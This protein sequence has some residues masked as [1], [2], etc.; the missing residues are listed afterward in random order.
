MAIRLPLGSE[1]RQRRRVFWHDKRDHDLGFKDEGTD[2]RRLYVD[3]DSDRIDVGKSDMYDT[4]RS[5]VYCFTCDA[6]LSTADV[7]DDWS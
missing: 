1:A 4:A 6:W 5:G 7:I 3:R 2:Y